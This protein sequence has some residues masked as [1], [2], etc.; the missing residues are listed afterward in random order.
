MRIVPAAALAATLL[1]AGCGDDQEAATTE[2]TSS[3]DRPQRIVSLSPTATESLFA[4]GAGDQVE[5][6]DAQSDYPA[7]APTSDLNSLEPNIEAIASYD[8]DLIV[9]GDENDEIET[10]MAELD[11]PV[12]IQPAAADFEEAYAQIEELGE[13]T[14]HQEESAELVEEMRA[15]I[16]DLTAQAP[17]LDQP[18]TFYHE[19]DDLLYT[20][21]SSTFI[22]QVYGTVGLENIADAADDGSG[23]PQLSAEYIIDADPDLIF[24]ADTECCGQTAETVAQRPGWAGLTAVQGDGVVEL[25]DD[26]ASR[27]GPRV[28]EYLATVVE[29][30]EQ[31]TAS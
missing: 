23:Y 1:L 7:E 9:L 24:L 19:L 3:A 30:M 5:A 12:L 28:V 2:T 4:I 15:E 25:D 17:A 16:E 29:A 31:V 10:A 22:G 20:A 11:V 14:G 18:L 26:V 13:V 27:W 6:V 8:P 21:T